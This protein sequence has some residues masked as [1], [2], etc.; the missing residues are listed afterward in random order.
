VRAAIEPTGVPAF[1]VNDLPTAVRRAAGLA[2]AG[3]SV[4][5]SPACASMDMFTN[6][7]HR[8]EVFVDAVREIALDRGQEI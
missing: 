2:K 7:A 5:L 1:D 6:Y 4:L 3:D 8:A